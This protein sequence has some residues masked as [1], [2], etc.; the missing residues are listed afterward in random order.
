MQ[1][2]SHLCDCDRANA[3]MFRQLQVILD[4]QLTHTQLSAAEACSVRVVAQMQVSYAE[5]VVKRRTAASSCLCTKTS[6]CD[7]I[8]SS[9][10]ALMAPFVPR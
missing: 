6:L 5:V 4:L 2:N 9:A 1:F 3:V 10:G 8:L 7:H